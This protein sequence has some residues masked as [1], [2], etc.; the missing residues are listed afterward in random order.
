MRALELVRPLSH[1]F[2]YAKMLSKLSWR[3][4]EMLLRAVVT[5]GNRLLSEH[6]VLLHACLIE[7]LK[8]FGGWKGYECPCNGE[9]NV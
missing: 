4:L 3:L 6:L 8:A 9:P 7:L 5:L 2:D 1:G